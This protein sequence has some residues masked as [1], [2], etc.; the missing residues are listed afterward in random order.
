MDSAFEQLRHLSQN[1]PRV[2][3]ATLIATR[4]TTPKKEGA[5]M[6]VG[7]GGRVLGSVTIGGCVD[8]RVIQE[9]DE[10]LST[11]RARRLV[12][13][14]G[15][16]EAWDL[17]LTCSG[18]VE[19]LIEPV[20]VAD[21]DSPAMWAYGVAAA[22]V[23]AGRHAVT[24]TPLAEPSARLVVREDGSYL[25]SLG[26][27]ALDEAAAVRA[28]EPIQQRAS[29]TLTVEEAGGTLEAFFEVHAPPVSLFVFGAGAVAIPL[30]QLAAT[31][32]LRTILVDGRPR[33]ANRERFPEVDELQVGIP[34]EIA[35]SLPFS[36][37]SLVVLVAHDYKYDIPVLKA[38]L[39]R[40]VAYIGLLGSRRRGKAILEYLAED[41]IPQDQ[42]E[43]I[44]VPVG[45]DIGAQTAAEIAL[46][47]LAEAV[48]VKGGRPGTPMR[49]RAVV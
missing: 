16:E 28:R 2:A 5:K 30:V 4:G 39:Q 6:W 17:G 35:E 15:D 7:A 32:G 34:S 25:G 9:A 26:N 14:L 33:F 36:T 40:D 41:D 1:E 47:I 12:I 49:D 11:G 20:D 29:R 21:P 23:R 3:M 18:S 44:R 37:S 42:L 45:L 46:S 48:A 38:V 10:T 24:V 22:E 43:R 19:V 8:A 31:L 13:S 27:K